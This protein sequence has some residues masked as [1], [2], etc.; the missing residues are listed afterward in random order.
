MTLILVG[1]L[2]ILGSCYYSNE[3]V[4]PSKLKKKKKNPERQLAPQDYF[5]P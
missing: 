2:E 3:T 5:A 4:M 1:I